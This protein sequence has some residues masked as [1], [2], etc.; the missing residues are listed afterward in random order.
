MDLATLL[1]IVGAVA[2]I[3]MAIILGGSAT[4]FVNIPSLVVVVGGTMATTLTRISLRQFLGSFKVGLKAFLHN[5]S[6][7]PSEDGKQAFESVAYYL[8]VFFHF[9]C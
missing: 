1:G 9:V 4:T 8:C 2:V 7:I 3:A 5:M 6:L